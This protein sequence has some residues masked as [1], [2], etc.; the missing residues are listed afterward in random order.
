V[1]V[2]LIVVAL[3][4]SY[5]PARR[6]TRV[7]PSTAL[8]AEWMAGAGLQPSWRLGHPY[9]RWSTRMCWPGCVWSSS[10]A[11]ALWWSVRH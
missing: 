3:L 2:G 1:P 4:A 5:L 6:A 11:G 8:R 7:D 10:Q 9:P